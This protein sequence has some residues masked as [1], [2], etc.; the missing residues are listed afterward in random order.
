MPTTI[1]ATITTHQ[2]GISLEH[3]ADYVRSVLIGD[4]DE[5]PNVPLDVLDRLENMPP[6]SIPNPWQVLIHPKPAPGTVCVWSQDDEG[7]DAW[8]AACVNRS[9]VLFSGGPTDNGMNYCMYCGR[10]VQE[11]PWELEDDAEDD[12]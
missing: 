2:E 11:N 7:S 9:F 10:P 4:P 8:N 12:E 6:H 5:V 1:T 3:L